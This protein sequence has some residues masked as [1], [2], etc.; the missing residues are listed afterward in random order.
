MG[1]MLTGAIEMSSSPKFTLIGT[2]GTQ[3]ERLCLELV[4]ALPKNPVVM[5]DGPVKFRF[6]DQY[7]YAIWHAPHHGHK[8]HQRHLLLHGC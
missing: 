4:V 1:E 2:D 3:A 6:N 8:S 7:W 5:T